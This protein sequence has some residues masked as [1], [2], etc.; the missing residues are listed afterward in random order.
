MCGRYISSREDSKYFQSIQYCF[1]AIQLVRAERCGFTQRGQHSEERFGAA[2]FLPEIFE[3][4]RQSVTDRKAERA[5]A[6]CVQE[7]GHL[8]PHAHGAVLEVAI[9]KTEPRID[10]DFFHAVLR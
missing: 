2:D 9:V 3:G 4:V 5:E 1:S 7:N 6:E 10:E 8:V